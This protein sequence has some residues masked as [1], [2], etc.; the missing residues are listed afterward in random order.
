VHGGIYEAEIPRG[1]GRIKKI[2]SGTGFGGQWREHKNHHKQY[3]TDDGAILNW[4]ESS[5]TIT[6]QGQRAAA[7][8]FEHAFFKIAL[9][10]GRIES[11]QNKLRQDKAEYEEIV[12]LRKMLGKAL[13]INAKLRARLANR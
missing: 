4:W 2:V 1:Y 7:L 11:E 6:F 10:K 9:A 8:R 12:A 3:R 13:L 5:G